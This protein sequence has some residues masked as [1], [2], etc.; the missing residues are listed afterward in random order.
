[1]HNLFACAPPSSHTALSTAVRLYYTQHQ[2]CAPV[3]R[4]ACSF[5]WPSLVFV[6]RVLCTCICPAVFLV[7][8]Q[9]AL[10]VL[11]H[12][13]DRLQLEATSGWC[14][15]YP[16]KMHMPL[17]VFLCFLDACCALSYPQDGLP[18][19]PGVVRAVVAC[20]VPR[21]AVHAPTKPASGVWP[22]VT[23]GRK[24]WQQRAARHL[25]WSC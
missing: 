8:H 6:T 20:E 1:M 15:N 14:S 11:H 5:L 7:H 17:P 23:A 3:V 2:A 18:E 13:I 16:A 21:S 24:C 25:Q 22:A 4:Q 9:A 19:A 10:H 12:T